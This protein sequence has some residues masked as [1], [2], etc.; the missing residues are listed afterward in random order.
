[1]TTMRDKFKVGD[2]VEG[3]TT[4]KRY[5]ILSFC[6]DGGA[7]GRSPAESVIYMS[8]FNSYSFV[9]FDGLKFKVGDI[10]KHGGTGK[11]Y[12]ILGHGY[13]DATVDAW[14]CAPVNNP[15]ITG[16]IR[17][18]D[19]DKWELVENQKTEAC[20]CTCTP[21]ELFQNMGCTC[22]PEGQREVPWALE[23]YCK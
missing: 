18:T 12:K 7:Y 22:R 5:R 14:K 8:N 11:R 10:V 2:T 6:S 21:R 3:T 15:C 13:D 1:M 20:E 9:E 17:Y 19:Q 23:V 16:H 4:G